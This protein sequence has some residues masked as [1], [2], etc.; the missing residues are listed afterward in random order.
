MS[1][2]FSG[3]GLLFS[4]GVLSSSVGVSPA[5]TSAVFL[6]GSLQDPEQISP[7]SHPTTGSAVLSDIQNSDWSSRPIGY[8]DILKLK[9][10]RLKSHKVLPFTHSSDIFYLFIFRVH[11][12]KHISEKDVINLNLISLMTRFVKTSVSSQHVVKLQTACISLRKHFSFDLKP[13]PKQ[14]ALPDRPFSGLPSGIYLLMNH[15]CHITEV[16]R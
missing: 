2:L 6:Q 9:V 3:R 8:M 13:Q 15:C 5:E 1:S 7:Q 4:V 10:F 16:R 14:D 12:V 11:S